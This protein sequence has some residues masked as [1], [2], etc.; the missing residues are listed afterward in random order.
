LSSDKEKNQTFEI[1][2]LS[3]SIFEEDG[4]MEIM[5]KEKWN[6]AEQA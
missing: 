5:T 3:N 2:P 1:R 4:V 6:N